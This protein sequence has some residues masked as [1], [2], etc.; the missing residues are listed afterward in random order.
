MI[1]NDELNNESR[2]FNNR[3]KTTN[4]I[5]QNASASQKRQA[6]DFLRSTRKKQK[7]INF[8][9]GDNVARTKHGTLHGYY[10]FDQVEKAPGEPTLN[11]QDIIDNTQRSVREIMKLESITGGQGTL[12][13]NCKQGC[14]TNKCKCK[15]ANVLCNSRCHHALSCCNK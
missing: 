2:P 15:Q 7:T 6:E 9:I 10:S 11:I 8:N 3:I 13:C 14:K 12:K 1:Q 5:R 4:I